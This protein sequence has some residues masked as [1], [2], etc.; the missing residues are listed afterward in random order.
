MK[1]ART[2]MAKRVQMNAETWEG[3]ALPFD[4]E[5]II[6]CRWCLR[7][8]G[9]T[10]QEWMLECECAE[11]FRKEVR[12]R[13]SQGSSGDF[14]EELYFGRI[15]KKWWEKRCRGRDAKKEFQKAKRT[16]KWWEDRIRRLRKEVEREREQRMKRRG[17][18]EE[19]TGSEHTS[20]SEEEDRREALDRAEEV[21]IVDE[22]IVGKGE[23]EMIRV[24]GREELKKILERK[25][26]SGK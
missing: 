23:P 15:T 19:S 17:E 6:E 24:S 16:M 20:D 7:E 9:A 8:H 4:K 25:R 14:E 13:W 22:G 1:E 21:R 12:E 3:N 10:F 5:R 11:D 2:K 26:K 18:E